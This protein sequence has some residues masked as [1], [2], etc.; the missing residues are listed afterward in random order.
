MSFLIDN[1][2]IQVAALAIKYQMRDPLD[3]WADL[4]DPLYASIKLYLYSWL[5][6]LFA[7]MFYPTYIIVGLYG[8]TYG[9]SAEWL[10]LEST[11]SDQHMDGWNFVKNYMMKEW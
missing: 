6:V 3:E 1:I 9:S 11:T 10:F 5:L 7:Y 4:L 2:P 8:L